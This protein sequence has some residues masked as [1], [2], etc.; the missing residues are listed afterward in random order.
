M[1]VSSTFK[2][3]KRFL[4]N[5]NRE[6]I[7][8]R[9]NNEL[10]QY[11]LSLDDNADDDINDA[12]KEK[13]ESCKVTNLK[14]VKCLRHDG[15]EP[16][17]Q[18]H[19]ELVESGRQSIANLLLFVARKASKCTRGYD[20]RDD[21]TYLDDNGNFKVSMLPLD[22]IPDDENTS[23]E[24][25]SPVNNDKSDES[26]ESDGTEASSNSDDESVVENPYFEESPLPKGLN[27]SAR[28]S[29]SVWHAKEDQVMIIM[30]QL[31]SVVNNN[32]LCYFNMLL[33]LCLC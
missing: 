27:K 3:R 32:Y 16:Y 12:D 31:L 22:A 20:L 10:T 15:F 24:P 7:R 26:G 13:L 17:L 6:E 30:D 23:P 4:Q 2:N 29:E 21:D 11:M 19:A 5:S 8:S 9:V 25:Q 1:T 14:S 28:K 33:K 18:L